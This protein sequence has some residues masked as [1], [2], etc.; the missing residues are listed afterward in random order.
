MP[1]RQRPA[2]NS[3]CFSTALAQAPFCVHP[4]TGKVCVPIDPDV[5]WE[6]DPGERSYP[7]TMLHSNCINQARLRGAVGLAEQ[8]QR[9][10]WSSCC[11]PQGASRQ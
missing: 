9:L 2:H 3:Y 10:P 11:T 4:K 1:I 5:A 7:A 6:F 8:Q